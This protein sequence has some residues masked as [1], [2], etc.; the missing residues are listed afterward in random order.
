[1]K[2]SVACI[3]RAFS[4]AMHPTTR[5]MPYLLNSCR[6]CACL[7]LSLVAVCLLLLRVCVPIFTDLAARNVLV[8]D[9]N[10]CK[11]ADFG[12]SRVIEDDASNA[13]AACVGSSLTERAHKLCATWAMLYFDGPR[14]RLS[15][16]P[17]Y[18]HH[19]CAW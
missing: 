2:A 16:R 11:V 17:G 14:A 6:C 18:A 15:S 19:Y 3:C 10:I 8:G 1:M 9:N 13:R 7:V 4:G 5:R 12:L